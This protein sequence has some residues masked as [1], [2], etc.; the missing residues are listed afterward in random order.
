[1]ATLWAMELYSYFCEIH[2]FTN[3]LFYFNI[4]KVSGINIYH[5]KIK[6]L[7]KIAI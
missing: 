2:L 1:M 5:Q 6:T 3:N 7:N 4:V